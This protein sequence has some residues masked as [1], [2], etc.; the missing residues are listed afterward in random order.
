MTEVAPLGAYFAL[1]VVA[2]ARLLVLRSR[3]TGVE[4]GG[5]A[6]GTEVQCASAKAPKFPYFG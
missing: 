5:G 1:L 4:L 3:E 6:A 2:A